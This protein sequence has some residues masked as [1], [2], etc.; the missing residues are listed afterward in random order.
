MAYRKTSPIPLA[1]INQMLTESQTELVKDVAARHGVTVDNLLFWRRRAGIK[2][3]HAL[4]KV[5]DEDVP[6]IRARVRGGGSLTHIGKDYGITKNSV[7]N[8]ATGLT[9]KT[10]PDAILPEEYAAIT[11]VTSHHKGILAPRLRDWHGRV[12]GKDVNMPQ[13]HAV[14]FSQLYQLFP[15]NLKLTF[16]DLIVHYNKHRRKIIVANVKPS[17]KVW[18][19]ISA[20]GRASATYAARGLDLVTKQLVFDLLV[21][22]NQDI[23]EACAKYGREYHHCCI[24]NQELTDAESQARGMGP[25]CAK[26]IAPKLPLDTLNKI[27]NNDGRASA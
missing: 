3:L 21:S 9:Y 12:I 24:C 22:L 8:I 26:R 15:T 11:R 4:R 17:Y 2:K 19:T 1:K 5:T 13:L 20:N 25:V 27:R 18:I 10:V 14:D 23:A 6:V 7:Y 16:G